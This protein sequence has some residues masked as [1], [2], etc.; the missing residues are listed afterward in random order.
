MHPLNTP[1]KLLPGQ[2]LSASGR[3]RLDYIAVATLAFPFM[4]NSAVQAVL[5]AT[6][7]WFIGRLSP[8]ATSAIGAVYWPVLVFVLLFGGVGLSVQTVVAQAYGAGRYIRASQATWTALWAS[9][10]TVP[11]F[12]ALALGGGWLFSPFGIS[13]ETLQLAVE[14]WFP[15][16]LGAPLGI[17]LWAV[18]GFFN[19]VGRPMTTLRVTAAVAVTNAI[20]NQLF[21]FNWGLGVA[22]S[23]W[24]TDAA[25]LLGVLLALTAFLGTP[26]RAR[27]RSHLTTRLRASSLIGQ[28]KLGFPMGVL[29]AADITGFALFQLMQVRLGTV[30]GAASQIVMMLT[31]FC[32]MPAVGIAMAG[33]TLVGQAI[34]A[35]TPDWAA[36][37]GNGIIELTVAYMGLSGLL[38]AALGPWILPLFTNRA[39]PRSAAV[40]ALG[41][42][43]LW[44]AAGYQLF[45][46]LNLG[47]GACLR[48]AGD[49]RIPSL[50][51]IALSWGFFVPLA[52]VLSFKPGAGWVDWLPQLGFGVVGGWF[53]AVIYIFF[54]GLML[55]LR[56]RSG[57]WRGMALP[58][59]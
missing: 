13:S 50:M 47:S 1:T 56:W 49:V 39:D 15:R 8:A 28:L 35:K 55:S 23:A 40:A 12:V 30:G 7:T 41:C 24:A 14:Y 59:S 3:P 2:A 32:Y 37:I 25:Q 5:N 53:A 57:A 33:T 18:L 20:L 21:V 48:G 34:G 51:V 42:R 10:F 31:S 4:L 43:L 11:A 9:L 6:D 27:Y 58:V 52:H 36:K 26:V 54:L 46:G 17:A 45:D 29:S 19:G 16:M 44:I 38:L 22:G